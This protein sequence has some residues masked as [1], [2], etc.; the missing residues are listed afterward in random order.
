MRMPYRRVGTL[1]PRT[2]DALVALALAAEMEI[3][4]WLTSGL[5]AS[6]RLITMVAV[7]L[8]AAPILCR[9]KWPGAALVACAAVAAAQ[10]P[11]G[12]DILGGM[13]GTLLPPLVLSYTAGARLGLRR[14][15]IS[16]AAAVALL[17]AG[18]V[19][20]NQVTQPNN[21]G[22][23]EGDMIGFAAVVVVPWCIGRMV[24]ER[25]DRAAAFGEL[26]ARIEQE[27]V[28]RERVAVEEE[29]VRIG[30]ELHDI[31]AQN[32][33]AIIVQAGGV[34]QLI[35]SDPGRAHDSIFAIEE[36]GREA[37]TDLRRTLRLLHT[38]EDR[39]ELAP[40]PGLGQLDELLG[41]IRERGLACELRM[42]GNQVTMAIGVD[43]L[44]YR[45]IE[46]A[47]LAGAKHGASHASVT[48]HYRSDRLE[49]EVRGDKLI[50]HLDEELHQIS[51][52]VTLYD[53]TM[54]VLPVSDG[55]FALEVQIP[56]RAADQ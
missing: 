11:L 50:P 9:G 44:C 8:Y 56:L 17:E 53:G 10:A 39:G 2:L 48:V 25:A 46:T 20:S 4:A 47:L 6:H 29:R 15:L 37:L 35:S 34:R 7:V 23:L 12:G 36:A 5:P 1:G 16:M 52:R 3:E 27:R 41:S 14:G 42:H 55:G 26:T 21:Y 51:E 38:G 31:I 33:S 24:R 40:Q 54:H 30:R 43:L 32:V 18:V 22:S 13:T 28:R 19:V 45:V 49:L